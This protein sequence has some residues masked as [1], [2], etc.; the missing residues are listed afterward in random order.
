MFAANGVTTRLEQGDGAGWGQGRLRCGSAHRLMPVPGFRLKQPGR[1]RLFAVVS[2][3]A[4][5][6]ASC[7]GPRRKRSSEDL[8]RLLSRRSGTLRS[9][10][11]SFSEAADRSAGRGA[12][13]D[14]L[15]RRRLLGIPRDHLRTG[16]HRC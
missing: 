14:G 8:F 13:R 10:S 11:D 15:A 7:A 2:E 6:A 1:R 4:G 3:P 9:R 5:T 12:A 16:S